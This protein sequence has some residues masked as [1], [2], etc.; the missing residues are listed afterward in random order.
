MAVASFL[1]AGPTFLPLALIVA[2]AVVASA[3]AESLRLHIDDNIAVPFTAAVTLAILMTDTLPLIRIDHEPRVWLLVN[4]IAAIAGY[5]MRSVDLSGLI[6]GWLL[7][8]TIIVFAHWWLYVALLVFFV[9]GTVATKLGYREKEDSGLAQEGGGRRGFGHAFANVGIAAICAIAIAFASDTRTASVLWCAA[10]A[11]LATAGADSVGTEVGQLL[12]SWTF[13]PVTFRRVPRGTEGAI[14]IEGTLA[15]A[16]AALVIAASGILPLAKGWV[17]LPRVAFGWV[18]MVA[19]CA[20]AASYIESI[21]GNWNR[22]RAERIP[23]G[24]LNFFNTVVGAG[25]ALYFLR[26]P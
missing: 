17:P 8:A 21:A 6:G 22:G 1:G 11:A 23:N 7:G 25:F 19:A 3:I 26:W 9:I 15:G 13:L 16:I 5:A 2:I 20:I 10:V 14:S 4:T 18:G 12:G 24:V